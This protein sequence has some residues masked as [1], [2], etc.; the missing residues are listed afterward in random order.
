[1]NITV[2][3][4]DTGHSQDYEFD[5]EPTLGDEMFLVEDGVATKYMV[6]QRSGVQVGNS[7]S[8]PISIKVKRPD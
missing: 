7:P 5:Y 3:F 2:Y 4:E 6:T 8:E 1:M